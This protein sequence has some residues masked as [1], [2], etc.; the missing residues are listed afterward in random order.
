M[1]LFRLERIT[2]IY[3]PYF[4][5]LDITTFN[6]KEGEFLL[7]TGPT[8]AGKTTLLK[9]LYREEKPTEGEI[10]YKNL[11]YS[12]LNRSKFSEFRRN[13]GIIFQDYKLILDL[14]VF[15]N[16][17]IS[18]YLSS[19]KVPKPKLYILNYLERFNLAP[20]AFKKVKELSGGEQ[21]KVG[22]IRAI[23]RDPELLIADEPTGNLDPES[24]KE[25]IKLFKEYQQAGK[26]IILATHD[27]LI[28]Q[29]NP[30]R[31]IRLEMGRLVENV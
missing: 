9:L 19:K 31:T 13:W 12:K 23:I 7:L 29:L 18:L 4:K 6:I 20:K 14:T 16:I 10:F 3:N 30:G 24:V 11:P 8:G 15:E 21:Q 1:D 17:Q 28:L 5:A 27:P 22:I 25:T 26:T 2:K